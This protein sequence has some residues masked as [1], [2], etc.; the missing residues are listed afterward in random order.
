MTTFEKVPETPRGQM[1][2]SIP[3]AAGYFAWHER[4]GVAHTASNPNTNY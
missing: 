4:D 1:P 2:A 3:T